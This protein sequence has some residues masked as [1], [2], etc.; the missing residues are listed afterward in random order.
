MPF[1]LTPS[2]PAFP[3]LPELN[4]ETLEND[5]SKLGLLNSWGKD[6]DKQQIA[7]LLQTKG[8]RKEICLAGESSGSYSCFKQVGL[9]TAY[10]TIH[11]VIWRSR[12]EQQ[13]GIWMLPH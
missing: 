11:I 9:V 3:P 4:K 5:G 7:G 10:W 2:P 12:Q 1:L 6:E 13:F 8:M